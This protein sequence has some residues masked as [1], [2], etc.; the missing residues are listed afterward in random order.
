MKTNIKNTI[1]NSIIYLLLRHTT[2]PTVHKGEQIALVKYKSIFYAI[3]Q[4]NQNPS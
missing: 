2:F 3:F 1:L 4:K